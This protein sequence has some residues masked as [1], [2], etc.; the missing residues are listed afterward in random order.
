MKA[1]DTQEYSITR[2]NKLKSVQ[3]L[4]L[5][6]GIRLLSQRTQAESS[7]HSQHCREERKNETKTKQKTVLQ[8]EPGS[9]YL[10]GD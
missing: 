5:P 9:T 10:L 3:P 1:S 7:D 2:H 8:A 4:P 6:V